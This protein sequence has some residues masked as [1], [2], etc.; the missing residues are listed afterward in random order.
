MYIFDQLRE[1]LPLLFSANVDIYYETGKGRTDE[2]FPP[3]QKLFGTNGVA[4][5][6]I[7]RGPKCLILGE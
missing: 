3:I 4:S 6:K 5:P 2:L 1:S 7:W